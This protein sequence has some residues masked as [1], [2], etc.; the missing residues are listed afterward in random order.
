MANI[1]T[2]S[3]AL[4]PS[5]AQKYGEE[6][7]R[8]KTLYDLS[9]EGRRGVIVPVVTT[10]MSDLIPAEFLSEE[11]PLLPQ[12]S[13]NQVVTYFTSL[14]QDNYSIGTGM[15]YPLGSCTMKYNPVRNDE[16]AGDQSYLIPVTKLT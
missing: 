11:P 13:E 12:L 16:V 2:K 5:F 15:L 10:P 6:A 4:D 3:A 1:E 8:G 14:S 7:T 9:V